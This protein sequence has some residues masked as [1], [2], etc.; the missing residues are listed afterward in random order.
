MK[1]IPPPAPEGTRIPFGRRGALA[2]L[3]AGAFVA[4]AAAVIPAAAEAPHPDA[5]LLHLG[6]L[7]RS[8]KAQENALW[9]Q[10][11]QEAQDDGPFAQAADAMTGRVLT[12]A[13]AIAGHEARTIEGVW[14]KAFALHGCYDP[15]CET[16]KEVLDS[17]FY[18]GWSHSE[19]D[20]T[21]DVLLARSILGDI[22]RM[23]RARE[24]V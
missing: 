11:E 17:L 10:A 3:I 5:A 14:L 4:P 21:C 9:Q 19:Y 23:S 13:R 22:S 16:D 12:L 7:Y 18:A 15:R 6:A 1:S 24:A 20:Q 2:G 8:L